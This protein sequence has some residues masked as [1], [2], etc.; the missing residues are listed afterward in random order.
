MYKNKLFILMY[1]VL[2]IPTGEFYFNFFIPMITMILINFVEIL[3]S[4]M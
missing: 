1:C 2:M 3:F 4:A